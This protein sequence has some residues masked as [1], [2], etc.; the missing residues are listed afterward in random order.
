MSENDRK[1]AFFFSELIFYFAFFKVCFWIEIKFTKFLAAYRAHFFDF[2]LYFAG[3]RNFLWMEWTKMDFFQICALKEAASKTSEYR[4]GHKI[5]IF[6]SLYYLNRLHI[7]SRCNSGSKKRFFILLGRFLAFFRRFEAF[8]GQNLPSILV[9]EFAQNPIFRFSFQKK[10]SFC[11]YVFYDCRGW[12]TGDICC[13][14]PPTKCLWQLFKLCRWILA[15]NRLKFGFK[16]RI[17]GQRQSFLPSHSL[18]KLQSHSETANQSTYAFPRKIFF[19]ET[20][21]M[22]SWNI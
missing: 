13:S 12:Y 9:M 4:G 3:K 14:K 8:F 19:T 17:Y 1:Y 16:G 2:L 18:K 7:G 10:T 5:F 22:S 21:N 11:F 6:W 20:Q 15:K